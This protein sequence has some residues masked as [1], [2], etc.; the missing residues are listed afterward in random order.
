MWA[1]F[2]DAGRMPASIVYKKT[3]TDCLLWMVAN[4]RAGVGTAGGV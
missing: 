3:D 4:N 2:D 1:H